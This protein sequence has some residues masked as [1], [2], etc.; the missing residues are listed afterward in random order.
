MGTRNGAYGA[1]HSLGLW[2]PSGSRRKMRYE[3]FSSCRFEMR[4]TVAEK[5][6]T[7]R[8][9]GEVQRSISYCSTHTCTIS[10]SDL[11]RHW[12]MSVVLEDESG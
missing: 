12:R 4:S 6:L 9:Q 2:L 1:G 7:D 8:E 11:H 3:A 10:H 5:M